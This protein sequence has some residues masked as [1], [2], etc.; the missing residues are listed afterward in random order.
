MEAWRVQVVRGHSCHGANFGGSQTEMEG[1]ARFNRVRTGSSR[2]FKVTSLESLSN[3][4]LGSRVRSQ[5][6]EGPA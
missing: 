5:G 1:Q 6:T 4:K 2:T 3:F